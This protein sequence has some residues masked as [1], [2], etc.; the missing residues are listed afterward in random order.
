MASST[1]DDS[2]LDSRD[3]GKDKKVRVVKSATD[4]QKLK[5]EKLMN[6][7]VSLE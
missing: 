5:L 2:S 1:K 4:L 7:P 6:K 3:D